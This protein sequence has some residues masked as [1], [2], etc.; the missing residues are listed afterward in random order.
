MK[1]IRSATIDGKRHRI[2]WRPLGKEKAH[3]L[4]WPDECRIDIDSTLTDPALIAEVLIHESLHRIFGH[5]NEERIDQIAS[6]ITNIL[7][8]AA[9]IADDEE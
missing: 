6:E 7:Q 9:L 1:R 8:R 3:G 2:V 5:L 4:A